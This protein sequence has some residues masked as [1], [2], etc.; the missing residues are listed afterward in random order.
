VKNIH[1]AWIAIACALLAGGCNRDSGGESRAP[2]VRPVLTAVADK[3]IGALSAYAG[4]I[5]PRYSSTLAFRVVGRVVARDASVGD[6]V[7]KNARLAALDPLPYDLAV[8]A[9]R[10]GLAD[11]EAQ[12]ANAQAAEGRLQALFAENHVPTQDLEA[13]Q[14]ARE[15]TTAGVTQARS[16]LDK[17]LEQRGYTELIAD[18]DGVVTAVDTEVGQ[19]VTP[20]QPVMTIARPDVREAVIDVPEDA[21]A[22]LQTAGSFEVALP[23]APSQRI[24]GRVR[25]IAPQADSLTR[26]RRVKIALDNPPADF[27]LGT[28][29]TAYAPEQSDGRI[30]I[31]ATALF[32]QDGKSRVWIVDP[33]S[34]TVT[35][36]EVTIV[37]RDGDAAEV[38][39]GLEPGDRIV[40]A[41]VN[42][43]EADQSV[44]IPEEAS[45]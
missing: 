32:E 3:E 16:A 34:K 45:K 36:R 41:G 43:L 37:S 12:F 14:Q 9:A 31:P 11:A 19:V 10:A 42:S 27:R 8:N 39:V 40:I 25:E 29:I 21:A 17:A 35:M 2:R 26:S 28:T 13:A 24:G 30:K 1:V 4:T 18:Y 38:S 23:S 22:N 20:G 33:A 44:R 7:K 5:E 6:S 15:A